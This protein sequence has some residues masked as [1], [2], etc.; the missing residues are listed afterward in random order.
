MRTGDLL[1]ELN[2]IIQVTV[3]VREIIFCAAGV[4]LRSS[5]YL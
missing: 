4:S 2:S 1:R 5:G 3:E